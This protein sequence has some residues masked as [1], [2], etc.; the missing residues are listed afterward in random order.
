[1]KEMSRWIRLGLGWGGVYSMG[2]KDGKG[3]WV[4]AMVGKGEAGA[5]KSGVGVGRETRGLGVGV[6]VGRGVPVG[7]GVGVVP[8]Q[9]TL[10]GFCGLRQYFCIPVS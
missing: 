4:G 8:A 5:E 6:G 7:V 2:G 9:V 3:A 10:V 1:M